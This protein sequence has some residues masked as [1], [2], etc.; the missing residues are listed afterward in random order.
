MSNKDS[1]HSLCIVPRKN[2]GPNNFYKKES[3][4]PVSLTLVEG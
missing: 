1:V 2:N 3:E 4:K